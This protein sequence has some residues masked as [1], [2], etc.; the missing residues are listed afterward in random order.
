MARMAKI[1]TMNSAALALHFELATV[2][3]LPSCGRD[4]CFACAAGTCP[5]ARSE[6]ADAEAHAPELPA[7]DEAAFEAL[8]AKMEI[9]DEEYDAQR[10]A[11]LTEAA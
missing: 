2:S 9:L 5:D 7:F 10:A 1:R 4:L 8:N 11:A 6:R 3:D